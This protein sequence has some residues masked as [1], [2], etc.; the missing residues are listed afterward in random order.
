MVIFCEGDSSM[1][2]LDGLLE[3]REDWVCNR[4]DGM[5]RLF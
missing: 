1:V 5:T 4:M 3:S 2:G